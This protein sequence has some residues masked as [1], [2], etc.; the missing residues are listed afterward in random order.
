MSV[1][2]S[3][4]V[5][6]LFNRLLKAVLVP[7]FLLAFSFLTSFEI[8]FETPWVNFLEALKTVAYGFNLAMAFLF[9]RGFGLVPFVLLVICF[10]SFKIDWTA[11]E[12]I[13]AFISAEVTT[14]CCSLY[15][16]F[17]SETPLPLPKC[18]SRAYIL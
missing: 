11:S 4:S 9:V 16:F 13:I 10:L 7:L 14:S 2:P 8:F 12:L 1:K 15:P 6:T 17:V 3:T 18:L 5:S